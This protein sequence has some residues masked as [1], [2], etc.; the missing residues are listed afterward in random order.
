MTIQLNVNGQVRETDADPET[1]LL[2]VL[3]N[4][5]GVLGPKFGCGHRP[6]RAG[7]TARHPGAHQRNIRCNRRQAARPSDR[8]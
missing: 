3:R 1:P 5:L 4:K 2:W 6:W 7:P 8:S